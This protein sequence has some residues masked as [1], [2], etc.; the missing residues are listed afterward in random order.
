MTSN[1]ILSLLPP[2]MGKK[3]IL[4][5]NQDV[6]DIIK[7]IV[8]AQTDYARHYDNIW[9]YFMGKDY[10]ST[11]RNVWN[12]LKNNCDYVVEPDSRQT[13]KT[14][15]AILATGLRK[16]GGNDCKNFALFSAGVLRAYR[17]ATGAD[18]NL[19][20][21]FAGYS[22]K[23]LAHVFV[24]I[25]KDG[26][27][28][29]VDPVLESFDNRE[30]EPTE[31]KDIKIKKMALIAL[32]GVNPYE[33]DK[34]FFSESNPVPGQY[35]G[36]GGKGKAKFTK[37]LQNA[38]SNSPADSDMSKVAD[39]GLDAA[40]GNWVGVGLKLV[41]SLK[42]LFGGND[43]PQDYWQAWERIDQQYGNPIGAS[44]QHWI[45]FDGD[46]VQNEAL[47]IVSYISS[48]DPDL[49]KTLGK[50]STTLRD[51]GRYVTFSDL[52]N[53]LRRGG[54]S[55]SA[56]ELQKVYDDLNAKPDG[57]T[58]K[59]GTNMFVTLALVGAAAY[60]LFKRK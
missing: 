9:P 48:N 15:A 26:K 35:I 59:A 22:G 49:S 40:S 33:N 21:R 55:Q 60:F 13:I 3:D 41:D 2:Y 56:D 10:K 39:I 30:H 18:F 6:D 37:L 7:G 57:E 8:K 27:E 24:V 51:A 12:F 16:Y 23:G 52:L 14:P 17:D 53:K 42:G 31:T 20:F 25:E 54:Y 29:W 58:T 38:K 46:S 34:S 4:I 43:N 1:Q 36:A 44:A 45:L 28:I 32:S 5:Y 19:Y 50:N 47:N 11:A